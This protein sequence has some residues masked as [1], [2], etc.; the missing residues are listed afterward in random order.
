[1]SGGNV[2]VAGYYA[3]EENSK[4]TAVYWKNGVKKDLPK[5]SETAYSYANAICVAG[6]QVY[7]GGK[8]DRTAELWKLTLDGVLT[9]TDE[10]SQG[11]DA[12]AVFV[13]GNDVYVAGKGSDEKAHY[14]K[15]GVIQNLE[16][17]ESTANSIFVWNNEVHIAGSDINNSAYSPKY[18]K[19]GVRYD[20]S[21]NDT[22]GEA[23]SVFVVER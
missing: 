2:Y 15:N 19:N 11:M 1:M 17:N 9:S 7:I 6:N 14:W 20:L 10:L 23:F 21:N 16:G 13:S 8:D 12:N 5:K 18:W 4:E 3:A 22:N